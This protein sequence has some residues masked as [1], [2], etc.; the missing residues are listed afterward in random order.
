MIKGR[1]KT[2]PAV[3]AAKGG[4][5]RT[6]A[7]PVNDRGVPK[8][9]GHLDKVA[10]EEWKR[11]TAEL[12]E[13][14]KLAAT[15]RAAIAIYCN[16]YSRWILANKEIRENGVTAFTDAGG[17]KGNPAVNAAAKAETTMASMLI[18]FGLTPSA[19]LRAGDGSERPRDELSEYIANRPDRK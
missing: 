12:A 2:S 4:K 19:R 11:I 17:V 18:S 9:P 1:K 14:G 15:D 16:C 13:A 10:Q 7:T 8:C 3:R 5:A 6:D